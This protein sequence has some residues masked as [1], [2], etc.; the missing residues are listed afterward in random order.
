MV[1]LQAGDSVLSSAASPLALSACP[2]SPGSCV[3]LE[4]VLPDDP[5]APGAAAAAAAAW[6]TGTELPP[7][8]PAAAA[9]LLA[10][11][12]TWA[13]PRPARADAGLPAGEGEGVMA[14]VPA[15]RRRVPEADVFQLSGQ[16]NKVALVYDPLTPDDSCSEACMPFTLSV[17]TFEPGHVTPR[18]SHVVGT[19]LFLIL[20]GAAIAECDGEAWSVVPGEGVAFRPGSV[21]ALDVPPG[22]A[23]V[24][25]LQLLAPDDDF[26]AFVRGGDA[27]LAGP[28]EER[29]VH[30]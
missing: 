8:G 30:C 10:D 5:D 4:L 16:Q 1:T 22:W 15:R 19:E 26:A 13:T 28:L 23:R 6:R 21:H 24:H 25:A 20:A 14:A 7:L 18:H 11:C 27:V 9:A 12:V 3:A 2:L 29:A 17:E